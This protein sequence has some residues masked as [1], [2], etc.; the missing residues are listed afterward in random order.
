MAGVDKEF[1]LET[2][3]A[4]T[5]LPEILH[6]IELKKAEGTLIARHGELEKKVY[7]Q[8]GR[9]IFAASNNPDDR[10]GEFLLRKKKITQED[11]NNSVKLLKTTK[12]RQGAIF[13]DLGCLT[14]KQLFWAVK[15][16]IMEM[17]WSLFNWTEGAISFHS[18]RDKQA[19]VIKLSTSIKDAIVEG[20]KRIS[21]ARRIVDFIGSKNT[22][23]E[24][25]SGFE[26]KIEEIGLDE[27][28]LNIA[29][30][31]DKKKTLYQV[32]QESML[33]NIDTCKMIYI[34][35]IYSVIKIKKA[36]KT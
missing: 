22:V 1:Q 9:V 13:V 34:L 21:N 7:I 36:K 12:K 25:S 32:C 28:Y 15:E 10:L 19:E 6:A 23:L 11:Y 5:P 4:N 29:Q 8:G 35:R 30:L 18:G 16:Q 2:D 27:N 14:P 3:L 33:G 26:K 31:L 24:A 17:V 20:V